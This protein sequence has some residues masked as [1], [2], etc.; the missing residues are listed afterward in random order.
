MACCIMLEY[1]FIFYLRRE[2]TLKVC[3]KRVLRKICRAER[4]KVK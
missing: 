4:E 3:K 2:K 1:Q